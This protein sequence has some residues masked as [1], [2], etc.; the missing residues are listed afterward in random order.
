[1]SKTSPACRPPKWRTFLTGFHRTLTE[2]IRSAPAVTG[3]E[4]AVGTTDG[5]VY[6]LSATDGTPRWEHGTDEEIHARSAMD[7]TSVYIGTD[8]ETLYAISQPFVVVW[9]RFGRYV[10]LELEREVDSA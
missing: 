2:E 6:S 1:M 3:G 4:V 9:D 7:D 10:G 8:G 5:R